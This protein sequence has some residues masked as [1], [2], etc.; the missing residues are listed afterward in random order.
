MN[1]KI[2]LIVF[3]LL[4]FSCEKRGEDSNNGVHSPVFEEVEFKFLK[5]SLNEDIVFHWD[6]NN[7]RFLIDSLHQNIR[8]RFDDLKNELIDFTADSTTTPIFSCDKRMNLRVGDLAYLL[9]EE[10][11]ELPSEKVLGVYIDY[12]GI[13]C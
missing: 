4:Y 13:D 1:A 12:L 11:I 8:I 2:T 6:L 3:S 7:N 5:V 9:L 10:F